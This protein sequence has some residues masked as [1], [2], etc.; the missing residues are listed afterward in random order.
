MK[1]LVILFCICLAGC[2]QI[3]DFDLELDGQ[4]WAHQYLEE[5]DYI[6]FKVDGAWVT[7][8][9]GD[10]RLAVG[11]V[12]HDCPTFNIG[13][14]DKEGYV[15]ISTTYAQ[16]DM[17]SKTEVIRCVHLLLSASKDKLVA[18]VKKAK[19]NFASWNY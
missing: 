18:T 15:T 9:M 4:E 17:Y 1:N 3:P 19:S 5:F 16:P 8:Y 11:D 7:A 6:Y 12:N 13:Q 10:Y 2:N 14:S